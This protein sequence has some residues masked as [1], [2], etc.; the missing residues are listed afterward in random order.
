MRIWVPPPERPAA[1][2]VPTAKLDRPTGVPTAV[3]VAGLAALI[4]V[5]IGG[6]ILLNRAPVEPT[7]ILEAPARPLADEPPVIAA[8]PVMPPTVIPPTDPIKVPEK[9]VEAPEPPPVLKKVEPTRPRPKGHSAED[10]KKLLTELEADA[11]K[12][13][14]GEARSR[15][16]AL[17]EF[18]DELRQG[19][20]PEELWRQ[21]KEYER[22]SR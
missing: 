14:P 13:P 17:Q 16:R 7:P 5:L 6:L 19:G 1:A 9:V 20:K 15:K 11:N 22:N 8:A 10:V 4:A 12:R 3:L 18:S 2:L 21:L